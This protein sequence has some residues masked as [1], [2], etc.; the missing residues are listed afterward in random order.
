MSFTSR[1]LDIEE[2]RRAAEEDFAVELSD[3][4]KT[5][6]KLI[7]AALLESGVTF[8]QYLEMNPNQR[9]KFP[10]YAKPEKPKEPVSSENVVTSEDV[11]SGNEPVEIVTKEARPVLSNNQQWLVKMERKNPLFEIAG[12]RFTQDHP[13]VLMNAEDADIVLR[14]EGFRQAYPTEVQEYYS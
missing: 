11:V 1:K 14:E 6:K 7:A 8:E 2:L 5:S 9:E 13:Y 10:E 3:E 12:H 4:E